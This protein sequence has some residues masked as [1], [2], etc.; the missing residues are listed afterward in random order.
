M[1][2]IAVLRCLKTSA[3]CAGTGCCRAFN[4]KDC[5]FSRYENE[6]IQ[7]AAMWTCNGCG[8]DLL[9]NQAGIQ[10]KIERMVKNNISIV[11][12][13]ECTKKKNDAG[14][15]EL[16]P[17]IAD[18]ARRLQTLGITVIEGTHSKQ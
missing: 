7:L 8:N 18:I 14:E 6:D 3:S 10:K 13:S 16:C 11:H 17:N 15:K 2:K 5:A 9:E 4:E 12:L 1:K